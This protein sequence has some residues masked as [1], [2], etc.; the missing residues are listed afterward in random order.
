MFIYLYI[1][2]LES[3]GALRAPSILCAASPRLESA[4]QMA[5][6]MSMSNFPS[7]LLR[8]QKSDRQSDRIG[9]FLF[10]MFPQNF[11][12]CDQLVRRNVL[13]LS[14]RALFASGCARM[15]RTPW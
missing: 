6:T 1:Y 13:W 15:L 11:N 8:R 3:S 10:V 12:R 9:H 4:A 2:I 5:V 14:A 7:S